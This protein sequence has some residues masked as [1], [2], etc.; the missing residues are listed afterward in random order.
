MDLGYFAAD[1]LGLTLY[2]V[3]STLKASEVHQIRMGPWEVDL[4]VEVISDIVTGTE[5]SFWVTLNHTLRLY[6]IVRDKENWLLAFDADKLRAC[7]EASGF[8]GITTKARIAECKP[9]IV[10]VFKW[11][12]SEWNRIAYDG[13]SQATGG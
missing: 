13:S 11:S 9:A 7:G 1:T 4:P 5:A 12:G 8:L 2:R 6:V 10:G 3:G